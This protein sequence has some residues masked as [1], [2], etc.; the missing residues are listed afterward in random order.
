MNDATDPSEDLARRR[1]PPRIQAQRSRTVQE[2]VVPADA[3]RRERRFPW[4]SL[5]G[6][7]LEQAGFRPGM[8][9]VIHVRPGSITIEPAPPQVALPGKGRR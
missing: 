2:M 4:L 6:R 3:R 8:L 5:S 9:T 1:Y 7:W